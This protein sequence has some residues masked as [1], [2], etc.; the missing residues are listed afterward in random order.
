VTAAFWREFVESVRALPG[1]ESA[2]V[3]RGVPIG[4]WAGLS[5][6]TA[7]KPNPPAG[8]VPDAN[9]VVVGPDYFRALRIPLRKGRVFDELDSQSADRVVI[10]NDELVRLHWPGQDPLGRRLRMDSATSASPWLSVVGVVGNVLSQGVDAGFHSE[11]YVPYQQYPWMLS[12]QSLIVRTTQGM[13]PGSVIGAVVHELQRLDR[14]QPATD[15]RTLEHLAGEPMA[16]QRMV[17]AL[18][19]AFAGLALVL[20]G[21]GI[22]GVLSYSVATRR[23]EIGVRIALGAHPGT[24]MRLVIGDGG[25]LAAIGIVAGIGAAFALTR[26]LTDLLYAVRPTDSLTFAVG[27]VVLGAASLLACYVPARRAMRVDPIEVLRQE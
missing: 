15:I 26:L 14:D 18:L 23:R 24:V 9:Y 27:I 1:V 10:V 13:T 4:D 8:E 7:D 5:F 2:S 6:T 11:I 16:Q 20:A 19:G 25:R 21:L 17:T 22:Y 12:P 3:S